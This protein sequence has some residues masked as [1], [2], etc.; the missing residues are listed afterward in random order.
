M[1]RRTFIACTCFAAIGGVAHAQQHP[2]FGYSGASGPTHWGGISGH[3]NACST[4]RNQS[5][6]NL[7]GPVEAELA[8][9]EL[10][11]T[12]S[13]S[14]IVNNTHSIQVNYRPGSTLRMDGRVYTL[15]QFHFHS[16]SEHH[17]EG[18]DF[19]LEAH[20]VHQDE[21]GNLAVSAVLFQEGRP[22]DLI[23]LLWASM[24]AGAGQRMMLGNDITV[25]GLLP[26][27]RRYI[28]YSGSLTTPP[29]SEGVLWLVMRDHMTV[30][31]E[32]VATLTRALGF[33]NNRPVQPVNAR[34]LLRPRGE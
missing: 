2:G 33:A 1:Q 23:D 24:P 25:A 8:P 28:R 20:L 19:P 4:G 34:A 10:D 22:N 9:L 18:R 30:S 14:E 29:C 16:P 31:S 32:Q 13:S 3:W 15:L 5:P 17:L 26:A 21:H 12:T 11:Y 27:N 6:V 7:A